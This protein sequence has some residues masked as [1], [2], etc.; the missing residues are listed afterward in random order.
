MLFRAYSAYLCINLF[1]MVLAAKLT[2]IVKHKC[3][4][5]L[6]GNMFPDMNPWHLKSTF[7]MHE[8]C[9][10]CGLSFIPEPGYYYGAMYISYALTVG[11][12]LILFLIDYLYFWK[13]GV[14]GYLVMLTAVLL[15]LSPYTLRTSRVIWLNIFTKFR[16]EVREKILNDQALSSR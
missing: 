3:P 16:P 14:K 10:A 8:Y 11:L 13:Y 9:P 5:C 1:F 4:R 15:I 2:S 12:S 7:K 6:E